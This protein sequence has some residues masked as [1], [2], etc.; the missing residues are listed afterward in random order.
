MVPFL[1]FQFRELEGVVS[2]TPSDGLSP[3]TVFALGP[4]RP[5][6]IVDRPVDPHGFARRI[7]RPDGVQVDALAGP[8]QVKHLLAALIGNLAV[9]TQ[10]PALEHATL[11]SEGIRILQ[12]DLL[13]HIGGRG[14][15]ILGRVAGDIAAVAVIHDGVL[16]GGNFIHLAVELILLQDQGQSRLLV[17]V[18]DVLS[19]LIPTIEGVAILNGGL[20]EFVVRHCF[21]ADALADSVGLFA[22]AVQ[23]V[24]VHRVLVPDHGDNIGPA[25]D[26]DLSQ[27]LHVLA[28]L[29]LVPRAVVE[30][31]FEDNAAG[32]L[33]RGIVLA[34][35]QVGQVQNLALLH[36]LQ[37]I[38]R[39]GVFH[40]AV[41]VD[42]HLNGL[43][44]RG[45][46]HIDVGPAIDGCGF[47]KG[48]AVPIPVV[49][50]GIQVV[51]FPG[52]FHAVFLFIQIVQQVITELGGA[53]PDNLSVFLVTVEDA[54]D[55]DLLQVIDHG[56]QIG[57]SIDGP[58]AD[59]V[60]RP[61]ADF[62][63]PDS[64]PLISG[65]AAGV[66]VVQAGQIAVLLQDVLKRG[67]LGV[68]A[69]VLAHGGLAGVAVAVDVHIDGGSF[70]VG[71][72]GVKGDV[73][74]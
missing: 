62:V 2:V 65:G 46:V 13:A 3:G 57:V 16:V 4:T 40:V 1:H 5:L 20:I 8:S 51:P 47:R 69:Q 7:L 37:I 17:F 70:L 39:I 6:R 35:V 45:V 9:L 50:G 56:T 42:D 36:G 63:A 23:D 33:G 27:A 59:R 68:I 10:S 71:Q 28:G 15:L 74:R 21:T 58:V 55:D 61:V 31:A 64:V 14:G 29:V 12:R 22:V 49:P 72:D 18:A 43:L 34:N 48:M 41:A 44:L 24:V 26:G 73:G 67:A 32:K 66:Q 38:G 30:P 52:Q 25:V 54:V 60:L 19:L 11:T 53:P